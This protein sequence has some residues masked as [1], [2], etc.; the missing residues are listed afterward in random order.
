MKFS[1]TQKQTI[2]ETKIK[3]KDLAKQSD[4]LF[5]DLCK[6][7]GVSKDVEEWL[8]DYVYND[9]GSLKLVENAGQVKPKKV[10][11]EWVAIKRG[12]LNANYPPLKAGQTVD[13]LG[14]NEFSDEL[15]IRPDGESIKYCIHYSYV[16]EIKPE[17]SE[18]KDE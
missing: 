6:S 4:Q 11:Q 3:I 17:I 10:S 12:V 8:F 18:S 15:V 7:L 13:I 16:K 2:K 5:N 1:K 9:F 14:F